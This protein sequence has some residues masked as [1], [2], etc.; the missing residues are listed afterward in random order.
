MSKEFVIVTDAGLDLTKE[1]RALYGIENPP[2]TTI[3]WPDGSERDADTDWEKMSPNEFYK[4]LSNKK[5]VFASSMPAPQ[6]TLDLFEQFAKQ[7]KNILALTISSTM[8]GG[9]S[10]YCVAAKEIMEKYPDIKISVIDSLRYGPAQGLLAIEASL[11]RKNGH[12][13]EETVEY[14]NEM[15]L[16][17]H[18]CGV[19]DDLFFLARKGRINKT[20]A[21]MG[22]MVGIKP[23]AD[24][25]NET[26]MS[27]VIGKARGYKKFLEV[28][29]RYV[30]RT[31]GGYK[32]KVMVIEHSL[33]EDLANKLVEIVKQTFAPKEL[34]VCSLNQCTGVN[35]GPGLCALFY[36]GDERVSPHCEREKSILLELLNK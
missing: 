19:L 31:I 3:V 16:H 24:F 8:S 15:R 32:N 25:C 2:R 22:S 14:I 23:M 7:G 9:Y 35:V 36:V 17:V 6:T 4:M 28:F 34:I 5:N 21:F 33:R 26:G 20:A 30:Q 12:T 27:T 29:P 11:Y 18:Q 10:G 1:Q 13:F